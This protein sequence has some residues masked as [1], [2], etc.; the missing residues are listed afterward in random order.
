MFFCHGYTSSKE[1][2]AYFAYAL[3]RAG[4]RVV[5]PDADRHGERFDGDE[6]R[7]LATF[8]EI[9]R[10]NIDELP[11]IK[12]HFERLGLIAD[13]RIGVAGASMGA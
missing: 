6:A 12:A 13:E 5:L 3:A 4:F 1:V 9:L 10:S 11:Q 2:Y 8:W 7:R